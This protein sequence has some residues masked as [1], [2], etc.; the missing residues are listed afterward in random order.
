MPSLMSRTELQTG[1]L[2]GVWNEEDWIEMRRRN[3]ELCYGI[4]ES[5]LEEMITSYCW[6]NEHLKKAIQGADATLTPDQPL[7]DDWISFYVEVF[8][9]IV[10]HTA[11][12]APKQFRK[13]CSNWPADELLDFAS[14]RAVL[15]Q[16]IST[17][18]VRLARRPR[19]YTDVDLSQAKIEEAVDWFDGLEEENCDGWYFHCYAIYCHPSQVFTA[20]F[21]PLKEEMPAELE[22]FRRVRQTEV[23]KPSDSFTDSEGSMDASDYSEAGDFT[24]KE[25]EA[26]KHER[27]QESLEMRR[28]TASEAKK[29]LNAKMAKIRA[30]KAERASISD[31]MGK[32]SEDE[33]DE[34]MEMV[35]EAKRA[36]QKS[37]YSARFG[38][39]AATL[40][41]RFKE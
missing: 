24:A 25:K 8:G 4:N 30:A 33:S 19:R 3:V 13:V 26:R 27:E 28:V 15:Y 39:T 9:N 21:P 16:V 7:P 10:R 12:S 11:S 14:L 2:A 36:K 6:E 17:Y 5:S 32:E 31:H 35:E 41:K 22:H 20:I 38:S 18:R 37:T 23:Q 1:P 34:L 40:A 29:R